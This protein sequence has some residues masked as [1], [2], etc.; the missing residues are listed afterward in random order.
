MYPTIP[1]RAV[2]GAAVGGAAILTLSILGCAQD[3][4]VPSRGVIPKSERRTPE[5]SPAPATE[6][7][8][9][10][11]AYSDAVAVVNPSLSESEAV[12][13]VHVGAA[14]WGVGVD[15]AGAVGYAAT[16]EGL[17]VIDL[18]AGKRTALVPYL[19]PAETISQGEY[20][21]G[22]LGLAV[23]PD[24]SRV[25]VAVLTALGSSVLEVYDTTTQTFVGSVDVGL[26][27]FDVLVAPDGSWVATIDH[28]SFS[29]TVVDA[30]TLAPVTHEV[31]PFGTVG[32]LASWEK[33]HYG[34]VDADG[35]ILLPV[36]GLVVLRLDPMTGATTSLPSAANSHSHGA[37]LAPGSAG[38]ASG[39]GRL[40]TVGTGAF[41]NATGTPNLS[42]LDLGS[43][44]EQIVELEVPHETVALWHDAE[45]TEF[46]VVAGGNTR[47]AG[48]NGLTLISLDTLEVRQLAVPGYPQAVVS[49]K[50]VA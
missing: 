20:R 12:T 15:A 49:F 25:Y 9:T 30:A 17:A 27:P 19:H 41:G 4:P 14:P 33:P 6:L 40:L 22:G 31:A 5:P 44:A 3:T 26:R 48:W 1:R 46:A 39:A 21:Q 45:G 24:G 37:A 34:E 18:V 23:A 32:G 42:I 47:D 10:S 7:L 35:G 38:G 28:D 11:L 36:Q 8:L 50:Q 2:L 43:G 16:A 13:L 29:V